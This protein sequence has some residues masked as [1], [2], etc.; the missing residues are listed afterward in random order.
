MKQ[1]NLEIA[2]N[3]ITR[4]HGMMDRHSLAENDGML[5]IFPRKHCQSFWMQN[6]YLPLDIAFLDDDGKIF[7]ISSMYPMNT[8]YTTSREPCRYAVEVNQGWFDKNN[9]DVGYQMFNGKE[10][11]QEA[12]R[13]GTF[14]FSGSPYTNRRFAQVLVNKDADPEEESNALEGGWTP[15][16]QPI[17]DEYMPYTPEQQQMYEQP[18]DPNNPVE[19]NMD[20]A[21][22]IQ[23]A[24]DNNLDMDIVYWTLSG[25]VLPPRHLKPIEGEGYPTESGPSGRYMTGFD[26]SPTIQGVG[27]EIKGLTPKNFTISN[28]IS[29][30]IRQ[31]QGETPVDGEQTIEEPQNMW[32]RLKQKVFKR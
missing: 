9:I 15:E 12:K 28:I 3:S 2:D 32:D 24:H 6:T 26:A 30:E 27:W 21:S 31:K 22:K 11:V 18:M 8:R 20:Q 19:Y 5:F 4:A 25:N 13:N 7:Q 16:Q 17:V 1:L 10:G 29:L 23:Y 14:K